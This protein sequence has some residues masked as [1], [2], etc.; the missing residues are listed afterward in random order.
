MH[1]GEALALVPV[2]EGVAL[3]HELVRASCATARA[4]G[5]DMLSR[6]H[7]VSTHL[8]RA[9]LSAPEPAVAAAAARG[10]DRAGLAQ[11]LVP[12]LLVSTRSVSAAVAWEAARALTLVG[13]REPYFEIQRG[14]PLVAQLGAR[15]AEL[16]VMAGEATDIGAFELLITGT[17]ATPALLSA[18]ARFGNVTAWSFLL[19]YL[20]EPDLVG[21]AVVA[22]R[23]LFGELV[24]EDEATSFTAWKH[25]IADAHLNPSER[26]RAGKPWH[27]AIVLA[28]CATRTLPR[29][30]VERRVDELAARTS[31][32]ASVDL[33]GWEHEAGSSVAAF[34]AEMAPRAARW[35]PGAWR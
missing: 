6:R 24:P 28:E 29:V 19:H 2:P 5:I 22:L 21:A 1:A 34:A 15:G 13:V 26:Y 20:A 3:G 31:V 33:S 32:R 12:E 10:A 9:H 27:P 30:E 4:V 25:A 11:E 16:L 8:L 14:G 17:P 7:A 23:T 18:V 35:R